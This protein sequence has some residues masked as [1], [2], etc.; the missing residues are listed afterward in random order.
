[1][2]IPPA[3]ALN[4]I[5]LHEKITAIRTDKSPS[6]SESL[7]PIDKLEAHV[8]NIRHV[9]ISNFVFHEEKLLIQKRAA[10]KYHSA[11]LWANTVCS[12]PRWQESTKDCAHRRLQ[13]EL[14]WVVPL[15]YFGEID[16]QAKVGDLY[17]NEQVHCF[18]G[19]FD[20]NNDI[21][22]FN[23]E[24]VSAVKWLSIPEILSAMVDRP[25]EFSEWFK[26]YMTQH[27][28]MISSLI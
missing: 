4:D 22:V 18:F 20:V 23:R 6:G 24:E 3:S 14:G 2:T 1:M 17:E 5:G 15:R 8:K 16:Y 27:R 11:G 10:T 19:S 25:E 9:A 7:Y 28:D 26:I 13:E 12:H 21:S